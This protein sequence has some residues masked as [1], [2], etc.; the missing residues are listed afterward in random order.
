MLKLSQY[1][2]EGQ[3]WTPCLNMPSNHPHE[4]AIV[5]I[6]LSIG[7]D[8]KLFN[9]ITDFQLWCQRFLA[10]STKHLH[11]FQKLL[12][13]PCGGYLLQTYDFASSPLGGPGPDRDAKVDWLMTRSGIRVHHWIQFEGSSKTFEISIK[14]GWGVDTIFEKIALKTK[15]VLSSFVLVMADGSEDWYGQKLLVGVSFDDW[16]RNLNAIASSCFTKQPKLGLRPWQWRRLHLSP[17]PLVWRCWPNHWQSAI[18]REEAG[19]NLFGEWQL[20][21]LTGLPVA[22]SCLVMSMAIAV[23]FV[24]MTQ[25]EIVRMKLLIRLKRDHE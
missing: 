11:I 13:L 17:Q 12:H 20:G 16:V 25:L 8:S 4:V 6:W 2:F 10:L 21:D 18:W 5:D 14:R 7:I 19:E 9:L 23:P 1:M 22:S 15:E 3:W 24:L